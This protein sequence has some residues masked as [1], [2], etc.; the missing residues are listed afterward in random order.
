MEVKCGRASK[1]SLAMSLVHITSGKVW[2]YPLV[3]K[4]EV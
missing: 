3:Y 1:Y 4:A 2:S